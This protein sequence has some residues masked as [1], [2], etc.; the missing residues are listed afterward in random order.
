MIVK[1]FIWETYFDHLCAQDQGVTRE[2]LPTVRT[3]Q[4]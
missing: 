1:D 2:L 3:C 4:S